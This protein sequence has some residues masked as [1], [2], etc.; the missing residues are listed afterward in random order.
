MI[1]LNIV[2]IIYIII[3]T[4][5]VVKIIKKMNN[6]NLFYSLLGIMFFLVFMIP[7]YL[8]ALIGFPNF[9]DKYIN[10]HKSNIDST[11]NI[12]YMIIT[13]AVLLFFIYNSK[14]SKNPYSKDLF[15]QSTIA[16][17]RVNNNKLYFLLFLMF[18]PAIVILFSPSPELYLFNYAY[19]QKYSDLATSNELWF[20]W[21]VLSN[22]N[23]VAYFSLIFFSIFVNKKPSNKI[24][25]YISAILIGVLNGKRTLFAFIIFSVLLIDFF[26]LPNK[27][28]LVPK[29][30]LVGIV[31]VSMFLAYATIIQKY[32]SNLSVF[33]SLRQYFFRDMDVKYSIY[34]LLNNNK[35][36][37]YKG[38]SIIFNILFFVPRSIWS[39]KPYP[40]DIYVTAA[41]LNL[42]KGTVINW[43]FQ[44]SLFG[45]FLTN[46]SW[47]GLPVS[48]G[49]IYYVGK[50]S[51]KTRNFLIVYFGF[52]IIFKSFMN[53][54]A[55]F[56]RELIVWVV[57]LLIHKTK[58]KKIYRKCDNIEKNFD[59]T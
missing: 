42:P 15:Y 5:L 24:I 28:K 41:V 33:D 44:T 2:R 18:S 39:G 8:D 7:I 50:I 36:L 46:L 3:N 55:S 9:E 23:S 30:I 56:N 25:T 34:N 45:E 17:Y 11:T 40:Y 58:R 31:L 10:F 48:L 59:Y 4:T 19:F 57:M 52:Y 21:N 27:R 53:H 14:S 6:R 35:I 37:N 26:K 13:S 54:F 47:F 20:H 49:V 51:L 38:E 32:S 22:F 16:N 29:M 1:F 12:I 43:S